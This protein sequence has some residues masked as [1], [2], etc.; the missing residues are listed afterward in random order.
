MWLLI[1]HADFSKNLDNE[2]I[3]WLLHHCGDVKFKNTN[4]AEEIEIVPPL[5]RAQIIVKIPLHE[6]DAPQEKEWRT[7]LG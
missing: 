1:N 6:H 4:D 2:D 7:A 3:I 5:I